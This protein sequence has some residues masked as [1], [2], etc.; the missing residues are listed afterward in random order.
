MS[1][2]AGKTGFA[3]K[4][5]PRLLDVL[6]AADLLRRERQKDE[7]GRPAITAYRLIYR[8]VGVLKSMRTSKSNLVSSKDAGAVSSKNADWCPQDEPFGVLK[9]PRATLEQP[10]RTAHTEQP[11]QDA[12]VREG[13]E[14]AEKEADRLAEKEARGH[15]RQ[16]AS[17]ASQGG[18]Q[19]HRRQK[20]GT[21][22]AAAP[23]PP[24]PPRA[25]DGTACIREGNGASPA[26]FETLWHVYPHR[27]PGDPRSTAASRFAAV[28]A[29]GA[30]PAEI[31]AGAERCAHLVEMD[32]AQRQFMKHVHRWL[33]GDCWKG[34]APADADDD[35]EIAAE[36]QP[37]PEV[38]HITRERWVTLPAAEQERLR[39]QP[40]ASEYFEEDGLPQIAF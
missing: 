34:Q 31:I 28:V 39:R 38:A 7:Y 15:R 33:D 21:D 1:K 24:Q 22:R 19:G 23:A 9:T 10:I 13:E 4:N 2:L 27:D 26:W 17:A 32:P 29:G 30:D 5:I 37:L 36:P 14:W 20:G 40:G 11:T 16:A 18:S 35:D 6:E 8:D 12:R 3:R 25:V